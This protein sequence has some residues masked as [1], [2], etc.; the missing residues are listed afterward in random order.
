MSEHQ[1]HEGL[2]RTIERQLL[3]MGFS[4]FRGDL[5][6]ELFDHLLEE[7]RDDRFLVR[8]VVVERAHRDPGPLC[9]PIRGERISPFRRQ[10][11]PGRF[12]NGLDQH[13]RSPLRR[14]STASEG[15]V[16][17]F[18]HSIPRV[19]VSSDRSVNDRDR[20]ASPIQVRR[21]IDSIGT[22]SARGVSGCSSGRKKRQNTI[23]DGR[24]S[25]SIQLGTPGSS[26]ARTIRN[27]PSDSSVVCLRLRDDGRWA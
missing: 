3:Q 15:I 23:P 24:P 22:T 11:L 13:L 16:L 27:R 20:L 17:F 8:V 10:D 19:Q 4:P 6:R 21:R 7:V 14:R 2:K 25:V 18:H 5:G 9:D 1:S 12:A 26:C